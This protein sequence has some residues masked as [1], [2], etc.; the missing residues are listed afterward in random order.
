[1]KKI[2]VIHGP[3][4]NLL[5]D[6]DPSVYGTQTLDQINAMIVAH[7]SSIDIACEC[8]QFN[9]ESAIID[10][11]QCAGKKLDGVIINPAGFTHTSV[12]IRDAIDAISIPVVEVHLS[13]IYARESF[14]HQ[15]LTAPVCVGQISGLGS[16][17]Y[18][19]ALDYFRLSL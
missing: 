1:M 4:L 11:L 5:G 18:R 12:A 6:R 14:R 16:T 19:L 8:T 10:A 2:R 3:N 7:A 9:S 17:G 15:S 13:H